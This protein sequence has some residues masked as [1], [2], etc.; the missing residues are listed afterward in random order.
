L[1]QEEIPEKWKPGKA[2]PGGVLK[3]SDLEHHNERVRRG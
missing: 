1:E 2:Y 3:N